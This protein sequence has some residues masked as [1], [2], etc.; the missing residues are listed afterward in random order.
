MRVIIAHQRSRV[1]QLYGIDVRN[2]DW[3]SLRG[4]C[5]TKFWEVKDRWEI[6]QEDL[7]NLWWGLGLVEEDV[8]S[9]WTKTRVSVAMDTYESLLRKI[10]MCLSISG[11]VFFFF[12]VLASERWGLKVWDPPLLILINWRRTRFGRRETGRDDNAELGLGVQYD[13][14]WQ[15]G[16][17]SLNE[18]R[19]G[20]GIGA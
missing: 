13:V 16:M 10:W 7:G 20:V 4:R 11:D 18:H 8:G 14:V 17:C 15:S 19:L 6:S 1:D 2:T 5:W 9:K 12:L 3:K